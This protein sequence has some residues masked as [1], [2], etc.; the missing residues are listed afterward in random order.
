MTA[1]MRP[2]Y[3]EYPRRQR[4]TTWHPAVVSAVLVF[5]M[6]IVPNLVVDAAIVPDTIPVTTCPGACSSLGEQSYN[7]SG[8][9]EFFAGADGDI[10]DCKHS[11]K[12]LDSSLFCTRLI[13]Q[14][15]DETCT[16]SLAAGIYWKYLNKTLPKTE[17][18]R[19]L[20][21]CPLSK[22]VDLDIASTQEPE[23]VQACV[24]LAA[25]NAAKSGLVK[26]LPAPVHDC[27]S[28]SDVFASQTDSSSCG[29]ERQDFCSRWD[30]CSCSK[31]AHDIRDCEGVCLVLTSV[32]QNPRHL[33]RVLS[34]ALSMHHR[35]MEKQSLYL[36]AK[37]EERNFGNQQLQAKCRFPSGDQTKVKEM[38][39]YLGQLIR[40]KDLCVSSCDE[41]DEF[42]LALP[43]KTRS[44]VL[45]DILKELKRL[46]GEFPDCCQW[47]KAMRVA[48]YL[49]ANRHKLDELS[50]LYK[51][52]HSHL[53]DVCRPQLICDPLARGFMNTPS[54]KCS[55]RIATACT[56]VVA[57]YR[58]KEAR[59]ENLTAP[60]VPANP[61][62]KAEIT[63]EPVTEPYPEGEVEITPAP[64]VDANPGAKGEDAQREPSANVHGGE[65][66]LRNGT[67][68]NGTV[69]S[70]ADHNGTV[71]SDADHNGTVT[72]G[73]ATV[74]SGNATVTSGA[75]TVTTDAD[76]TN[77]TVA[78]DADHSDV[79]RYGTYLLVLIVFLG[80][81][82][83]LF[84]YRNEVLV[85]LA[86]G[87]KDKH[88]GGR[89]PK[90][91]IEDEVEDPLLPTN[92]A[93]ALSKND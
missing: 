89:R 11:F 76:L 16:S 83:A 25:I 40:A 43:D 69:V 66:S 32:R 82:L 19:Y 2:T 61:E 52:Q 90:P 34:T 68:G 3:S 36:G 88:R 54:D 13:F 7:Y 91:S 12:D 41:L 8:C 80:V 78:T 53:M 5:A 50:A 48:Q 31:D 18:S 73:N 64:D 85:C 38:C 75:A 27:L 21:S 74:T 24:R 72:S 39:D 71:V 93:G 35:Y 86:Q 60:V 56:Q 20:A 9:D 42:K 4:Y 84:T 14:F 44:P 10:V 65:V 33:C 62:A 81:G 63:P 67:N 57:L 26:L 77:G 46:V 59:G 17:Y 29:N 87:G 47:S 45:Q 58:F 23:L 55:W 92:L 22:C 70:D 28:E 30:A 6:L 49:N 51:P 37:L 1:A 15:D 79:A